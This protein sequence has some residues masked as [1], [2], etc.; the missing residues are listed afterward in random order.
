MTKPDACL[1]AAAPALLAECHRLRAVNAEL[2]AALGVLETAAR[3]YTQSYDLSAPY[4]LKLCE[5]ARAAL[6]KVQS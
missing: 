6:A 5:K 2:V 1:I 4:V 3:R